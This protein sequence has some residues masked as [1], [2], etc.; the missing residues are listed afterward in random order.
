MKKLALLMAAVLAFTLSALAQGTT[1]QE[2]GTST[3]TQTTTT[4]KAHG[5]KAGAAKKNSLTGCLEKSDGG[6]KLTNAHYKNGIDVTTSEDWSAH[7]G[8]KVKLTGTL[9]KTA[10]PPTF[11]A[12]NLKHI[13]DTCPAGK[14]G[15]KTGKKGKGSKGAAEGGTAGTE[16]AAPAPK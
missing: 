8:H 11:E 3:S 12:T 2:T 7:V 4:K 1:S 14:A 6:Y 13:S 9:N 5:K 15:A 16:G 10:T